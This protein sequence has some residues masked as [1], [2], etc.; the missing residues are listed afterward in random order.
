MRAAHI[1]ENNVVINYVL[2]D[3]FS[4]TFIDPMDSAI[5]ST[6]NGTSFV[7]PTPIPLTRDQLKAARQAKVDA[8]IVTVDG[9]NFNGDE[10]SQSRM[11]RAILSLQAQSQTSTMWI[12]ADNTATTVTLLQLQKALAAAG[13][14]QTSVWNIY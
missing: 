5:G 12:L 9:L 1:D 6:W 2:V 8:S 4:S 10:T 3:G 13:T 14:Y 11:A 7:P